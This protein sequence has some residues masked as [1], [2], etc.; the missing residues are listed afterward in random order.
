MQIQAAPAESLTRPGALDD[1]LLRAGAEFTALLAY[2]FFVRSSF[3]IS[4]VEHGIR[5]NHS[6]VRVCN[7]RGNFR[8]HQIGHKR[9]PGHQATKTA[10]DGASGA[11]FQV[12][13]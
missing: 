7:S 9:A 13:F 8:H 5:E 3:E 1:V 12:A 10:P 11:D 6:F 2:F 4:H